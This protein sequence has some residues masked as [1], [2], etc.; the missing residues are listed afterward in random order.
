MVMTEL[1]DLKVMD[2]HYNTKITDY[3]DVM[4]EN[5]AY[6]VSCDR[7]QINTCLLFECGPFKT[8]R[9]VIFR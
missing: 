5:H 9:A 4:F 2:Q 7:A 3:I 8:P 1:R 6:Q